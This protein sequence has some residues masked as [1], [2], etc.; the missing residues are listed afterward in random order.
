[1][2]ILVNYTDI[3]IKT[4]IATKTQQLHILKTKTHTDTIQRPEITERSFKHARS[5]IYWGPEPCSS[6]TN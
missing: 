3:N 6:L 2:F 1:M 4:N 5:E